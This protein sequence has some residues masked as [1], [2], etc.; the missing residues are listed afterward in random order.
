MKGRH[1]RRFDKARILN[2]T[3]WRAALGGCFP[4]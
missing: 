2:E 3:L 4:S 1:L